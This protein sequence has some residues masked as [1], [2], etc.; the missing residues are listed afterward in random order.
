LDQLHQ[1][2]LQDDLARGNGQIFSNFEFRGISLPNLK[3]SAAPPDV[4]GEKLHAAY[5]VLAIGRKCF[6]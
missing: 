2:V 4:F 3:V 1:R 6:A 5:Q